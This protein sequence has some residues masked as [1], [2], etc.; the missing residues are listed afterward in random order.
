MGQWAEQTDICPTYTLRKNNWMDVEMGSSGNLHW[1]DFLSMKSNCGLRFSFHIELTWWSQ[2]GLIISIVKC[3]CGLSRS[4][5]TVSARCHV[6]CL[7]FNVNHTGQIDLYNS[8]I[9]FEP[10]FPPQVCLENAKSSL[11]AEG[12]H[13]YNI[14]FWECT[15]RFFLLV[16][17]CPQQLAVETQRPQLFLIIA[18][19]VARHQ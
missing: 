13:Q 7:L 16:T 18:H 17:R 19:K 9:E 10:G 5:G 14:F 11:C 6:H 3:H 15:C 2:H 12:P 1:N 8:H 4:N